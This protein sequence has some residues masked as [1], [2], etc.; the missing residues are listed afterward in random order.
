MPHFTY[1]I[2]KDGYTLDVQVGL[3]ADLIRTLLASG[4]PIPPPLQARALLDSASDRTAVSVRLLQQLA[5]ASEGPV[6]TQTAGGLVVVQMY[7]VS[8]TV[9]NPTGAR[10][11][12]LAHSD[13]RVTEFLHAPPQI[14][15][16][17]GLDIL[18]DCLVVIDGPGGRFTLGF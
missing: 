8:L 17:I 4:Q 3:R 6:Q 7:V 9:P 14:D 16:L 1:P 12:M 15:I 13:L 18:N 2:T 5:I 11:P 10:T